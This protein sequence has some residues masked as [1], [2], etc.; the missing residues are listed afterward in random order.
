MNQRNKKLFSDCFTAVTFQSTKN[1]PTPLHSPAGR[2]HTVRFCENSV[3]AHVIQLQLFR[4][5]RGE[6]QRQQCNLITTFLAY[7]DLTPYAVLLAGGQ[8]AHYP[9]PDAHKHPHINIEILF[10]ICDEQSSNTY[11]KHSEKQGKMHSTLLTQ[12]TVHKGFICVNIF[13]I[14]L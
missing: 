11:D 4:Q 14:Q 2:C 9:K 10:N 8:H 5:S 12:S 3:E 6:R 7:S 1:T 13:K